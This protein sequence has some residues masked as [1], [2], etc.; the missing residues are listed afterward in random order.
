MEYEQLIDDFKVDKKAFFVT[1][2]EYVTTDDGTGIVHIAPAF[3]EDDNKV[4]KEYELPYL[5]PIG[6]SYI[7]KEEEVYPN[8]DS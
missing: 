8:N 7:S 2:A 5:N 4:G 6:D 1:C 3:G